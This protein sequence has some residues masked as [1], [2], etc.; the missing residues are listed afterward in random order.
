MFKNLQD[1]I[2]KYLK[3][4]NKENKKRNDVEEVWL[5]NIPKEIQK[6]TQILYVKNKTLVLKT[7]N[8]AWRM[9]IES[10][11]E[12]IKKKLTTNKNILIR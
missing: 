3:E 12:E 6:H 9:E 8:P 7:K 11:K 4:K 2:E 10:I 1:S 5:K